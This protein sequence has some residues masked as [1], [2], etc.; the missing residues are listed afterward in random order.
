MLAIRTALFLLL[1]T[2]FPCQAVLINT[3]DLTTLCF[4]S[5]DVVEARLTRHH[6][7]GQP[8]WK[9]RFTATVLNPLEGRFQAGNQIQGLDLTLYDPARTGQQC[10]LFLAPNTLFGSAPPKSAPLQA[11][12]MVLIDAHSRV[13]RYFQWSNPG[14]LRAE[15]YYEFSYDGEP[16]PAMHLGEAVSDKKFY[17]ALVEERAAIATKWA[18]AKK[19]KAPPYQVLHQQ[20]LHQTVR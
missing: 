6:L 19:L 20:V 4:L 1:A 12:D 11:V 2:A 17:P 9:D 8:E 5:T 14:G 3:Y 13:R 7:P 16:Y 18:A 10:I 15:G